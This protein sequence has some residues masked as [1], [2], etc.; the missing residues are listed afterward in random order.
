MVEALREVCGVK[1]PLQCLAALGECDPGEI[2]QSI[3]QILGAWCQSVNMQLENRLSVLIQAA[4][5]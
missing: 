5:Q 1:R 3:G 4:Y 2:G